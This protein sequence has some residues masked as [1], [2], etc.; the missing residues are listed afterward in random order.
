MEPNPYQSPTM[1]N[2]QPQLRAIGENDY[3]PFFAMLVIVLAIPWAIVCV[4]QIA[5]AC[6]KSAP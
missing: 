3:A 6:C 1:P 5:E 4:L 2:K